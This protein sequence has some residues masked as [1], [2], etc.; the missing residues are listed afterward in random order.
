MCRL[1]GMRRRILGIPPH[2]PFLLVTN[3]VSYLDI[4]LLHSVVNGVFI[5]KRD[6]KSW[7]L[8][9]PL[10]HIMG[11]IWVTREVRRDALRVLD[12]IDDAIHRGDGVILF[13]EGT[14]S[15]GA[16]LLPFKPALL[17]WA[18]REGYPVHY[19]AISYRS[20]GN[21]PASRLLCW[22]GNTPFGPHFLR[23]LRHHRFEATVDFASEPLVAPTRSRLA[24]S[25]RDA[26]QARLVPVE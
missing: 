19:A 13:P 15:S 21:I 18:A 6:M 12:Q 1:V 11:T 3:H 25:L 14:T 5:A 9:G 26:I 22:W 23:V 10:A 24:E 2:A 8:L 7:P 20:G 16:G 17:D 4:L